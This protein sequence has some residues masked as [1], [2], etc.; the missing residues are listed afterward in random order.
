M[1]A[2]RIVIAGSLAQKPHYG[3]HTWVLLQYL[4]GFKLLGYE[5]LFLDQLEPNMC[6]DAVGQS[7]SLDQSENL[8][9]LIDV[10]K[11][12]GLEHNYALLYDRGQQCIGLSKQQVLEYT[13]SSALLIN[14]MGFLKDEDI[15]G[16]ASRRVFLDIDP[17]FSQMWKE[18]KLHDPFSGYD[19]HVTIGENIGHTDCAIP[20]CNLHWITT[21]Q[22]V[23]L[24]Y[25]SAKN[26]NGSKAVTSVCSWRG[27]YGP[28]EY[29]EMVYGLRVHE[30]RRFIQLPIL[31]KADFELALN[32]HPAEATDIAFLISNGWSLKNPRDV[33]GSTQ[34]YQ[35]YIQ[36]SKAEFM[37]AKNMYVQSRSGWFSDR[38]ICYLAS[39]KPALVQ[40][41]GI[42]RFYPTGEGLLTFS[43][44]EEASE[45]IQEILGKYDYHAQKAR[46]IAEEYFDSNK[47]LKKLLGKLGI[48]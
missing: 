30:F 47:V 3:G 9:Y 39:G 42:K 6:V 10:M 34:S 18:L 24:K 29:K 15:L 36:N 1:M 27:A 35:T 14:I 21:P 48:A 8:H 40:D 17:G 33:A 23:V 43:N 25:W 37:V 12:Y 31:T 32:I 11:Q 22:P 46:A 5:I 45:G 38:S 26:N 16:A 28:I 2:E 44:L 13:K 19:Y 4:L 7:C 41:S 20:T